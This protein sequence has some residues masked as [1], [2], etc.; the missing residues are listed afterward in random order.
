MKS[1]YERGSVKQ[2]MSRFIEAKA[3][4]QCE[5]SLDII[6]VIGILI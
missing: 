3:N 4:L 2:N 1:I 5:F 6:Q